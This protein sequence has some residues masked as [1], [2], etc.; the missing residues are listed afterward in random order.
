M[1]LIRNFLLALIVFAALAG[2]VIPA[3]A[4]GHHHK[5]HHHHHKQ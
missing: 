3:N 1:K 2:S 5:H 4:A